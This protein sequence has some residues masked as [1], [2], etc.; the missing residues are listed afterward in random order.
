MLCKVNKTV[1]AASAAL[2]KGKDVSITKLWLPHDTMSMPKIFPTFN[3]LG[4]EVTSHMEMVKLMLRFVSC[5]YEKRPGGS[6]YGLEPPQKPFL[7]ANK[8]FLALCSCAVSAERRRDVP[9]TVSHILRFPCAE[10]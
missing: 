8:D 4:R 9:V 2:S 5:I 7:N 3:K 6:L 1:A 10:G